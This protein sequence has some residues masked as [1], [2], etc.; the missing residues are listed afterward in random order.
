MKGKKR[1]QLLRYLYLMIMSILGIIVII[2]SGGGGGGGGDG[3]DGGTETTGAGSD[4]IELNVVLGPLVEAGISVMPLSLEETEIANGTTLDADDLAEAGYVSFEIPEVYRETPLLVRTA[5]GKNIDANDD[6]VRDAEPTVIGN[7]INFDFAFPTAADLEDT[8]IVANPLVLFASPYVT[9]LLYEDSNL[10]EDYEPE[11]DPEAVRTVMRRVAKALVKEDVDGDGTIDWQDIVSF[12]PL[13]DQSKSRMPW[14]Y[15]VEDIDRKM[16]GYDADLDVRYEKWYDL[17]PFSLAPYDFNEDGDWKDE[18][19]EWFNLWFYTDK[20]DYSLQ[21]L[22]DGQGTRGGRVTLP[23]GATI[24]Y[25]WCETDDD[26]QEECFTE[27]NATEPPLFFS[28]EDS[29]DAESMSLEAWVGGPQITDP[30]EV[31]TGEYTVY[32]RTGDGTEHQEV[33]YVYENREETVFF[34]V[35]EVVVDSEGFVESITF[36]FEDE[37]GNELEDPPILYAYFTIHSWATASEVNSL[38]RGE[39]YYEPAHAAY[40]EIIYMK[41]ISLVSPT[42]PFYPTN[43]GH[44]I[45]FEDASIIGIAAYAGDGVSRG[46]TFNNYNNR[47]YPQMDGA[48]E[49][50]GNQVTVTF[51]P[52]ELADPQR[53]VDSIRY[54]FDNGDWAEAS[55]DT[56]TATIP[57]SAALLYV[58]AKDA[59]GYYLYPPNEIDLTE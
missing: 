9:G 17:D 27:E 35:P 52:A 18:Q 26:G 36:R 19:D 2:S 8:S 54:K 28:L 40:Y 32:Y 47:F 3:S 16:Q 58:T 57:A 5:G 55:G 11:Q 29:E 53:P 22:L 49:I 51:A 14:G 38:V 39:N 1:Q 21:D 46:F 59:T 31:Q 33:F 48:A 37:N 50:V 6:G 24:T 45:Y 15:V 25:E 56:L 7:N 10:P 23:S 13:T 34:V 42:I 30:D 41:N 12:H 20:N 44:G 43:N 4:I